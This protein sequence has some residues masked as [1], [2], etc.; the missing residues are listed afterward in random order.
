MGIKCKNQY[1]RAGLFEDVSGWRP[2]ILQVTSWQRKYSHNKVRVHNFTSRRNCIIV[3][4]VIAVVPLV[5]KLLLYSLIVHLHN[6]CMKRTLCQREAKCQAA[7]ASWKRKLNHNEVCV[8]FLLIWP[9]IPYLQKYGKYQVI[10][11]LKILF[12]MIYCSDKD[13][14]SLTTSGDR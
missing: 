8:V 6:H 13:N 9:I 1:E 2:R 5:T 4:D 12:Y 14:C 10:D 7:V 3:V 11:G